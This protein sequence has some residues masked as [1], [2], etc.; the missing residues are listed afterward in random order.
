MLY[1]MKKIVNI[2][3]VKNIKTKKIFFMHFTKLET[4]FIP[5]VLFI[6]KCSYIL[7]NIC[8][9]AEQTIFSFKYLTY[10]LTIYKFQN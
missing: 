4:L 8:M 2:I 1:K 6:L 10:S 9:V 5:A 3:V 7:M